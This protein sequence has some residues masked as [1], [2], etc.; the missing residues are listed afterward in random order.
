[1]TIK[2]IVSTILCWL[3]MQRTNAQ[4]EKQSVTGET[5]D[6]PIPPRTR[7]RVLVNPNTI[8]KVRKRF[9]SRKMKPVKAKIYTQAAAKNSGVPEGEKV[10]KEIYHA[11]DANAF[12]YLIKNNKSAGEQ[13]VRMIKEVMPALNTKNE[14]GVDDRLNHR[15][16]YSAAMVYDWC[17]DLMTDEDRNFLYAHVKR[18][19][20]LSEYG[21]PMTEGRITYLVNHFGE[22][23]IPNALAFGIASYEHSPDIYNE[24]AYHLY[25]GLVPSR[26]SFYPAHR[27]HQGSAYGPGRYDSEVLS[28]FLITQMG[29][30]RPYIDAQGKILY[31]SIYNRRPDDV[32]FSQGDDF[33]PNFLYRAEGS[34]YFALFG[35]MMAASEFQDPYLQDEVQ[36]HIG[37]K[38]KFTHLDD[39]V[40]L[41][42]YQDETLEPKSVEELPL[43]KFFGE[44]IASMTARTGWDMKKGVDSDVAIATMEMSNY[45]FGNHDHLDA[46]HFNIYYKG[47][48]AIDSGAYAESA[49][50]TGKHGGDSGHWNNYF[51]RTVA[52]NTILVRDPDEPYRPTSIWDAQNEGGQVVNAGGPIEQYNGGAPL[53]Y[54]DMASRGKQV[55]LLARSFG[56]DT[57]VPE[58][59]Y[60]KGDMAKA[61]AYSYLNMQ[62]KVDKAQRSFV[63]FN[64][65]NKE[66]PAALIV[67]DYVTAR[68]A[69]FKKRWLMHFVEKPD[70]DGHITTV[71]K[72]PGRLAYSGKLVNQTLWPRAENLQ[73]DVIGGEGKEFW[74]ES[75]S[76]NWALA[77]KEDID[78][79]EAGR[80]RIEISPKKEAATDRFLNV[81][82]VMDKENEALPVYEYETDTQV[83][84]QLADRAV[85]FSKDGSL[86]KNDVS[87]TLKNSDS[88]IRVLLTDLK[89]GNWILKGN[90]RQEKFQVTESA[91]T[92]YVRL[93][94]GTYM[95]K[96]E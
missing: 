28:T 5:V 82:Q 37:F 52:H 39:G 96:L 7:P 55:E 62:P 15:V 44:P 6:F 45:Y 69:N 79:F 16:I 78:R 26:N 76:K 67:H 61:Y 10:T 84:V 77:K 3:C 81:I 12:L 54:Q 46:G 51:R 22:E 33:N 88:D 34:G 91:H 47:P 49:E 65:K 73:I 48:L 85:F 19:L 95:V 9:E 40:L 64:L 94:A 31:H 8:N 20:E 83:G 75:A 92:I 93:P 4:S 68:K 30:P 41:L 59:S 27:H 53:S 71:V 42:L 18:L 89:E 72:K 21:W 74:T 13:A 60:L 1:M 2:L 86:L 25:G 14:K 70:V 58:Y 11:I 87:F 24:A 56:P 38:D 29:A 23:K 66:V 36:R 63:F 43:T 80:W 90:Q 50:G 57:I 17:Y 32:I 35:L